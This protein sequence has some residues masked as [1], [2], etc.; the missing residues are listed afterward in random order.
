M[1]KPL[2]CHLVAGYPNPQACL[3]LMLGLQSIGI[4]ALEVQIPFSDP[5]A[6]GETIMQANDGALRGGMTTAGSFELVEAARRQGVD[7]DMYVMSYVQKVRH[8][9]MA[10][11]CRRAAGC[12]VKGLII[13]DL[14]YDSPE[15][16]E[17]HKLAAAHQ[18]QLVPVLSPDMPVNRLQAVLALQPAAVYVTSMRGIT[19]N[20][21]A[22]DQHLK[23]LVS[24]IRQSSKPPK[25]MIGFGIATPGDVRDALE[26]GD[27]AVA[28]S[29]VVKRL[30]SSTVAE[31]VQFVESLAEDES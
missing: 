13:P 22:P 28:G 7:R 26:I 6:D 9:G 8:F 4:A 20:A 23:Q 31:T 10:D 11:F 2:M 27:V 16:S 30:Q 1:N 5:I 18:L 15:F 25:V 14:P 21:Y 24:D 29:A 12:H 19:G 3:E 17:L